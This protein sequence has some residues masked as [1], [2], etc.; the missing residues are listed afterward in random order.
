MYLNIKITTIVVVQ[1][2]YITT[3]LQLIDIPYPLYSTRPAH[4]QR[5]CPVLKPIA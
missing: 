4:L 2:S 3:I 5:D 1:A